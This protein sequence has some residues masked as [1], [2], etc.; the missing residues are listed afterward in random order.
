MSALSCRTPK[1]SSTA[2]GQ[3]R[4]LAPRYT[5]ARK[6]R[7]AAGD[8]TTKRKVAGMAQAVAMKNFAAAA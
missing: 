5:I 1:N 7:G 6:P 4:P 8:Q 2:V 3:L